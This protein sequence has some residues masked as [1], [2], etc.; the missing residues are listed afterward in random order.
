MSNDNI[1]HISF[2]SDQAYESISSNWTLNL[3]FNADFA[4]SVT[5]KRHAIAFNSRM[6]GRKA[7]AFDDPLA[8]ASA[9]P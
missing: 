8:V 2:N 5:T 3:Q 1:L 4:I 9:L 6:I 7:A